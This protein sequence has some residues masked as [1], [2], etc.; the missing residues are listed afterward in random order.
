MNLLHYT[1]RV[2][3]LVILFFMALWGTVF[4]YLIIGNVMEETD[5]SL[6]NTREILLGKVLQEPEL[7]STPDSIMQRY[8][9]RELSDEEA[10]AYQE[11]FY[12]STMYIKS[13]K[14]TLP[15]RVMRSAFR[16]A[17]GR[18]YELTLTVSTLERE[19]LIHAIWWALLVLYFVILL[20]ITFG[21]YASL[22]RV[23]RPLN[24]LL[25][26]LKR[27]SPG[28]PIPE[29]DNQTSIREFRILNEAAMEMALRIDRVYREQKQ[30]IENASHELQTPLA[31][32]RGKLELLSETDQMNEC[33]LAY[34]NDMFASLNKVVQ[35]NK[36]LLLLSRISNGQFVA[37]TDVDVRNVVTDIMEDMNEIYAHKKIESHIEVKAPFLLM[38]DESLA[39]IMI[40]NLLKNAMV[41]T[42]HGGKINILIARNLLEIRNSGDKPLDA[43]LIFQRFY[44]GADRNQESTGL[45]LALVKSIA[46][47]YHLS[48]GYYYAGEHIF[49]LKNIKY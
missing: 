12:D 5:E 21:I 41:H 49:E 44:R 24:L 7:L 20:C 42:P 37:A 4:Y 18:Y 47:Y 9:F 28:K 22:K 2:I 3:L 34:V 11:V 43:E 15:V 10:E 19:D 16:M 30:F 26:W 29:L 39:H 27:I 33:Q 13:E 40:A 32:I 48:L 38:M 36:S 17:D 35:L 1:N 46:D 45:G 23:F 8:S 6:A 31:V 14:E 25:E